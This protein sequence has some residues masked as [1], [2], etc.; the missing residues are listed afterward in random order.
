M[1][2]GADARMRDENGTTA[3]SRA[4][5]KGHEEVRQ[6]LVDYGENANEADENEA[7]RDKPGLKE[8]RHDVLAGVDSQSNKKA[9]KET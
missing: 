9:R 1:E 5:S 2:Y 3:L 7:A 4:V 6:L 8:S